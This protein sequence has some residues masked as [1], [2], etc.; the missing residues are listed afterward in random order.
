M[1]ESGKRSIKRTAKSQEDKTRKKRGRKPAREKAESRGYKNRM[2]KTGMA[3]ENENETSANTENK[4]QMLMD[5]TQTVFVMPY[6][7][8]MGA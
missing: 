2:M 1:K 8:V 3:E 6:R 7:M 4:Q 5:T